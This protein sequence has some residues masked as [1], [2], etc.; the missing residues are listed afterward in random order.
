[1]EIIIQCIGAFIGC[2]GFAFV[3]RIHHNIHFALLGSLAGT[4]GWFIYTSMNSLNSPVIQTFVAMCF[5]SLFSEIMARCF[6]A[7]ATIFLIVGC[8]TLVPGKGIYQTMYYCVLGD[9]YLFSN[10]LIETLGISGAIAFAIL[11]VSTIFKII[12]TTRGN[13]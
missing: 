6:H 2:L 1:M 11:I 4:A 5:V 8:F 13:I 10:A 3:F 12:K 9:T 7:P